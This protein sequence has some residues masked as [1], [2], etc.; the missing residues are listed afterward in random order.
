V[1]YK[2]QEYSIMGQEIIMKDKKYE[3]ESIK[4][5]L[6]A[7]D[8]YMTIG[9]T[10]EN[11][12]F[13]I[14]IHIKKNII[15]DN[16]G[17]TVNEGM[18]LSNYNM[19]LFKIQKTEYAGTIDPIPLLYHGEQCNIAHLVWAIYAYMD[20]S[21][22]IQKAVARFMDIN[23]YND[24]T[25]IVESL[26]TRPPLPVINTFGLMNDKVNTQLIS[27][28]AF[29]QDIDG[30]LRFVW[31]IDQSPGKKKPVTYIALS[32]EGTETIISKRMTAFDNAVYNAVSTRFYYWK[33]EK[34]NIPLY[35][36]PQEIWRTMNGKSNE[37]RPGNKQV[38]RITRSL[39]KMRVTLCF[40]DISEEL[41]THYITLNDE[42]LVSGNIETYLLKADKVSF[43]TEKGRKVTGYRFTEEPILYTY[44][45]AKKHILW[46]DYELLDTSQNTSDSEHVIEFRNYLLLQIQNMKSKKRDSNR[47]LYET[48]YRDTGILPA[49][50]RIDKKNYTTN[51]SYQTKIRQE[52]KKDREKVNGIL[53]SWK[54]KGWINGYKD[55]KS[56]KSVIAVDIQYNLNDIKT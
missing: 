27:S 29:T 51:N 7:V 30:Q 6:Q 36:T 28:D 25:Y 49:D 13:P 22:H 4:E 15:M 55:V 50:K 56:R 44:N 33:Q 10:P 46:F 16:T 42:R 45:K 26:I 37:A 12:N 23:K 53:K 40:M 18:Y 43:K 14:A 11:I 20:T 17:N 2:V 31:G 3:L 41:N 48:L 19:E 47:I 52:F 8:D 39:D 5:I 21:E 24:S 9:K 38:E 35:I 54:E 1:V 32:Y 34:E